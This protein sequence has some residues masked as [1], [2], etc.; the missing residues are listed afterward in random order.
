MPSPVA[1][2]ASWKIPEHKVVPIAV[3]YP[4]PWIA[5]KTTYLQFN[6]TSTYEPYNV[7]KKNAQIHYSSLSTIMLQK[8]PSTN[9]D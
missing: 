5:G 9:D 4:E 7:L 8:N 3:Q 2:V 6:H 1:K